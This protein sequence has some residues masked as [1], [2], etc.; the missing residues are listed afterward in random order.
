MVVV[1]QNGIEFSVDEGDDP[2][3]QSRLPFIEIGGRNTRPV[4]RD[5]RLGPQIVVINVSS[6]GQSFPAE[7]EKVGTQ[8]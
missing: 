2:M 4:S 5:F 7:E 6:M 1:G 3:G 8:S